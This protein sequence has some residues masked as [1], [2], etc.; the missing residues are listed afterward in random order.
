MFCGGLLLAGILI[1]TEIASLVL[2]RHDQ[3]VLTKSWQILFR[4]SASVGGGCF[5]GSLTDFHLKWNLQQ[6]CEALG[7]KTH[8]WKHFLQ[9]LCLT[10]PPP[11]QSF[12]LSWFYWRCSH[13][14]GGEGT[15]CKVDI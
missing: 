7:Q 5:Y 15:I 2:Q 3:E 9:E 10:S 12:G 14:G 6:G 1:L 8:S 13:G 11:S 4:S